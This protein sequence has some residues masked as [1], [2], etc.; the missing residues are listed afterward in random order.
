MEYTYKTIKISPRAHE[1]ILS[2]CEKEGMSIKDFLEKLTLLIEKN[3]ISL[4]DLNNY[5]S[6]GILSLEKK[7]ANETDRIIRILKTMEKEFLQPINRK[8]TAVGEET[9]FVAHQIR[10]AIEDSNKQPKGENPELGAPSQDDEGNLHSQLSIATDMENVYKEQ[11]KNLT[12]EKEKSDINLK[13]AKEMLSNIIAKDKM[14]I[15][16]FGD[17]VRRFKSGEIKE[18][19]ALISTL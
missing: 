4:A 9:I 13:R 7:L 3:K 1:I 15:N 16:A 5:S 12:K 6:S 14:T 8:V 17:E 11:I 2:L 10:T 19:Q 18:I